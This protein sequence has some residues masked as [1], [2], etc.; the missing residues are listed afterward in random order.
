MSGSLSILPVVLSIA[1]AGRALEP[2]GVSFEIDL[3]II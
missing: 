3:L 1:L 2:K